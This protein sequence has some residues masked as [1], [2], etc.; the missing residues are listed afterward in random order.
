[1][2]YALWR[3][4]GVTRDE[5]ARVAAGL[6]RSAAPMI[7]VA[8]AFV[9]FVQPASDWRGFLWRTLLFVAAAAGAAALFD[10]HLARFVLD[11]ARGE[12]FPTRQP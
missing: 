9:V 11:R 3:R 4:M 12:A 2:G 8:A 6:L 10:R 7:V 5:L 1:M